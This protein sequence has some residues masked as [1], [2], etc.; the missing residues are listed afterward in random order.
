D[1]FVGGLT[2]DSE[3]T[4]NTHCSIFPGGLFW[5]LALTA[6]LFRGQFSDRRGRFRALAAPDGLKWCVPDF[7][8]R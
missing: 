3:L 7:V 6:T 4:T 8:S 5:P 2:F 1:A